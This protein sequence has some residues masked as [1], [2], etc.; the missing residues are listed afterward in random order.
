MPSP[1]EKPRKTTKNK[2]IYTFQ[3]WS[4]IHHANS[5][6]IEAYCMAS[7]KRET[8]AETHQTSGVSSE[9]IAE[10]IV[11][12]VNNIEKQEHLIN[13]M[14]LVIENCLECDGHLDW[15]AEH[16]AEVVLRHAKKI[17]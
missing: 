2:A 16:D 11:H 5:S 13:E 9:A 4:C 6:E 7:G 12:A 8:I 15:S 17:M 3:K 1:E 10:F 14:V